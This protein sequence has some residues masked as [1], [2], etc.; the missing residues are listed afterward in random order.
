MKNILSVIFDWLI[1]NV[2]QILLIC[3]FLLLAVAGF[4]IN[5]IAGLIVSGIE[6]IVIAYLSDRR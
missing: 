2:P 5:T 6:L 4:K 3:G 1:I